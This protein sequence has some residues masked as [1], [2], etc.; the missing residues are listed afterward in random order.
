MSSNSQSLSDIHTYI[1]KKYKCS[2]VHKLWSQDKP[3]GSLMQQIWG[4]MWKPALILM[5]VRLE[6]HD[7]S[8]KALGAV[9]LG[10][11]PACR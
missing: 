5:H 10:R 4:G 7:C 11:C 2:S 6:T 8:V 3:P 9:S 1:H